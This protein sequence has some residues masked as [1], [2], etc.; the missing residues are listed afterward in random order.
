MLSGTV[1]V[2]GRR[3]ARSAARA[4]LEEAAYRVLEA[5]DG[6]Q[7][8]CVCACRPVDLL[9]I[10]NDLPGIGAGALAQK[11]ALPFPDTPVLPLEEKEAGESLRERVRTALDEKVR[12]PPAALRAMARRRSA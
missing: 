12:R 10:D 7:A 3:A 4:S 9:L 2:V 5:R 11:I 1:L 6:L 8:L